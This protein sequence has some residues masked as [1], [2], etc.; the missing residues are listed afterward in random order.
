MFANSPPVK[1]N[2][3]S[4]SERV[5]SFGFSLI[6]STISSHECVIKINEKKTK[7]LYIFFM[8]TILKVKGYT[9]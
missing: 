9:Q 7:I 8:F 4:T 3:S 5:K 1:N 6:P 2:R